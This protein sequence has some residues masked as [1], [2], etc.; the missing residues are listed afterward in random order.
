ML[1]HRDVSNLMHRGPRLEPSVL[2]LTGSYLPGYKAGGPIRSIENLARVLSDEFS[3]RIVTQDRDLGDKAPF[4]GIVVNRW[5]PVGRA[6]VMYI[7]PRLLGF[8]GLY[9]ILRSLDKDTVLYLNSF[10]ARGFSMLAMVMRRLK[11][12]RPASVVLAPRGEFSPGALELKRTRKSAYIRISRWLGLYR[13]LIW[14]ASSDFEADD[15]RR[16]FPRSQRVAVAGVIAGLETHSSTIR[17]SHVAVASDLASLVAPVR[18]GRRPKMPGSLRV[19]FVSRLS[20]KKNLAGAIG[21]LD[22]IA[23]NVCF[24]IYGPIE[25]TSY[26]N[27]CQNLIAA[28]PKNIDARYRGQ[29]EHAEIDRVFADHDL[30]LFPTFGENYGHVICESLVSGCPVLISDQTPWRGLEVLE[31]GWD[32]ALSQPR[33]FR[34]VLQRCVDMGTEEHTVMCTRAAAFGAARSNAPAVIEENR[35]LFRLALGMPTSK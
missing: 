27:E 33:R 19:V 18:R 35:A 20:R 24:D 13:G 16:Q 22:S 3:F 14:H 34:E 15:I 23:G 31:V 25:D 29:T 7:R 10:F 9:S 6:R 17:T 4:P 30:F 12:C 8:I 26:W 21:M 11:L 28:L 2:I 1:L 5:V 32:L